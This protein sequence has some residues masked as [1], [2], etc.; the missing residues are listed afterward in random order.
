MFYLTMFM[1][2]LIFFNTISGVVVSVVCSSVVDPG[3]L[4]RFCQIKNHKMGICY[5]SANGAVLRRK[6]KDWL[7]RNQDNMSE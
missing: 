5:F 4:H 7:A 3:F 1:L 6:I 2:S